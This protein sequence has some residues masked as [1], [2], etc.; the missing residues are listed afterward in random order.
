MLDNVIDKFETYRTD[1]EIEQFEKEK[2]RII[3]IIKP[4]MVYGA[5]YFYL[6]YYT[7]DIDFVNENCVDEQAMK[8]TL[9]FSK[10]AKKHFK[11][12]LLTEDEEICEMM[13]YR[14]LTD[15]IEWEKDTEVN[16]EMLKLFRYVADCI[17]GNIG[18]MF[19]MLYQI[20]EKESVDY[21]LIKESE[22]SVYHQ[23]GKMFYFLG[24]QA[25]EN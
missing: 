1:E 8:K 17:T 13:K 16:T 18:C 25:D 2:Q 15:V 11:E 3:N 5:E 10:N 24:K 14:Y 4:F 23:L 7:H 6:N 22:M 19:S 9:R 20:T 21:D 12:G